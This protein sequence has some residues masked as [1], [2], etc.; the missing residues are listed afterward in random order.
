MA[1]FLALPVYARAGVL[2]G[3]VLLTAGALLGVWPTPSRRRLRNWQRAY[4]SS[5]PD[6]FARQRALLASRAVIRSPSAVADAVG[7][8]PPD[9]EPDRQSAFR[10]AWL[11]YCLGLAGIAIGGLSVA[12]SFTVAALT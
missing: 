5:Q 12:V 7:E 2:F 3:A 10:W 1:L 6:L 4:V 8:L 11:G 9:L